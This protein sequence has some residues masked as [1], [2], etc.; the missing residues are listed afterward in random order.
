MPTR[1]TYSSGGII[2]DGDGIWPDLQERLCSSSGLFP[3]NLDM[4]SLMDAK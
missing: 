1:D 2:I 3:K 4:L